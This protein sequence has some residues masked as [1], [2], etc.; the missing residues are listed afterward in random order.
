M[1]V[2]TSN[3]KHGPE[4]KLFFII[5]IILYLKMIMKI[6]LLLTYGRVSV[7]YLYIPQSGFVSYTGVISVTKIRS[8]LAISQM[9][10]K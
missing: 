4:M 2:F 1:I 9:M 8:Y 5:I 3:N 6:L 7:L 10:G